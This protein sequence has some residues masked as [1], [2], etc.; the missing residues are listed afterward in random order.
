[1]KG[2]NECEN[3]GLTEYIRNMIIGFQVPQRDALV[4]CL[5]MVPNNQNPIWDSAIFVSTKQSAKFYSDLFQ[6]WVRAFFFFVEDMR[7]GS[8]FLDVIPF[9][10][11]K[12][13]S[14]EEFQRNYLTLLHQRV[15]DSSFTE[16]QGSPTRV[17]LEKRSFS[18]AYVVL[19]SP[20]IKSCAACS[21]REYVAYFQTIP[22]A[23]H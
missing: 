16:A 19:N 22:E 23:H 6:F 13:I 14:A 15:L 4:E 9:V 18:D 2:L 17:E 21:D 3:D 11:C 7:L 1:M 20:A 8:L 10:A 5:L 12:P